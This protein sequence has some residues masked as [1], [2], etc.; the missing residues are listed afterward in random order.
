MFDNIISVHEPIQAFCMY[1][2]MNGEGDILLSEMFTDADE[3]NSVLTHACIKG[4]EYELCY[5]SE[6]CNLP[7]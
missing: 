1:R 2:F 5:S 4:I 6:L 7:Q 3:K